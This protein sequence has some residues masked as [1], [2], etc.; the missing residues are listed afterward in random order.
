[1]REDLLNELTAEYEALRMRNEQEEVARR[2]KIRREHPEIEKLLEAREELIF[3]TIHRILDGNAGGGNLPEKMDE[4]NGDIAEALQ[5]AGFPANYLEPIYRC[6]KCRDT[7]YRGEVIR[8]PCECLA[9]AYARKLRDRIGLGKDGKETFEKFDASLIPDDMISGTGI[10]QRKL[11]VFAREQCE[12]WAD[13]YPKAAARDVLLTGGTGLGKTFLMRAM[14]ARLIERGQNV[15]IL[16]AY[17]FLQMA[18]KSYFESEN[19]VRELMEVPVLMMDDLGSEPLMQN[20]TV[21]QLF[22]LLNERQTRGL[23][24]VISTN[25]TLQELRERYTERIASRLN[26]PKNCL[27]ITLAGKDLRTLEKGS[28]R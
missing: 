5:K 11:S 22:Y 2:E 20:I 25:L 15:L 24:T 26:N 4:L 6:P 17:T 12:K 1:M 28:R 14:A 7:G 21:E 13:S 23:S 9:Q 19:G 16:S 8:E 3:G 27:I 18:R 10:T